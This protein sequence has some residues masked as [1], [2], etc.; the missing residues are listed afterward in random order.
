MKNSTIY[1]KLDSRTY[2]D[3]DYRSWGIITDY[4]KVYCCKKCHNDV[5]VKDK[6]CHECGTPLNGKVEDYF[7]DKCN[8]LLIN[9]RNKRD[10][11]I[12]DI[13]SDNYYKANKEI[14]KLNEEINH[15]EKALSEWKDWNCEGSLPIGYNSVMNKTQ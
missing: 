13:N 2:E 7:K 5:N 1:I 8:K 6:F 11:L 14:E 15:I 4:R 3:G 9:R 12:K 10:K